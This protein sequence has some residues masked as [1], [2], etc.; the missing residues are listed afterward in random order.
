MNTKRILI[1]DD[2]ADICEIAKTSLEITEQWDVLI[3]MSGE[4]GLAIAVSTQPDAILLD[5][6]M[7]ECDGL[8]TLGKLKS[9]PV[10]RAIPV[11][12]LTAIVNLAVQRQCAELNSKA[13]LIKPFDPGILGKQIA[14]I[15]DW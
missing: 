11:I 2:E 15:L 13:I 8:A 6:V 5:V 14:K 4:E 1:I 9:D 7:P 10:T 3:A 12:M